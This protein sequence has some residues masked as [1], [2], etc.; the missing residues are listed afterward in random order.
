MSEQ[1]EFDGAQVDGAD[2]MRVW[3]NRIVGYGMGRVDQFIANPMNWK[4][5]TAE[6]Y[7]AIKGS[8]TEI[9]VI[10]NV[11]VNTTTLNMLDG[12]ARVAEAARNGEEFLPATYVELSV[13]EEHKALLFLDPI[14]AMARADEEKSIALAIVVETE[15]EALEAIRRRLLHDEEAAGKKTDETE[16][17]F[18]KELNESQQYVVFAFD[19]EF[20]WNVIVERFAIKTVSGADDREGYKRKGIGRVL[21]G[22][23]LL[24]VLGA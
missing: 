9:G 7:L 6:Q 15:N 2:A 23:K 22:Q 1:K 4:I 16:Y 5:H 3:R 21:D 10:Q 13:E 18:A 17:T 20:D 19:N 24:S 14:G 11:I 8:F 12:H